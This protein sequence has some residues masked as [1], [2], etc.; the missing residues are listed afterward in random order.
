MSDTLGEL[1]IDQR[2]LRGAGICDYVVKS[3]SRNS[4]PSAGASM[5]EPNHVYLMLENPEIVLY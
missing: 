3:R 2:S 1:L 5:A 4:G